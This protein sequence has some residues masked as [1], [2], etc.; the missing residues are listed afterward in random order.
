M[1]LFVMTA[2]AAL[3]LSAPTLAQETKEAKAEQM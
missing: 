1:K 3:S 2:M